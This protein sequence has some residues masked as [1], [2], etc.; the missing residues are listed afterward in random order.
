[1][2]IFFFI[3]L[4]LIP[5]A[6]FAQQYTPLVNI[7]IPGGNQGNFQDYINAIYALSIS[8]AALLA[9]IKI[10]IAGVKWMT[11]DIVPTKGEAKKDIQGALVGLLLIIGAVLIINVIN[12][13]ITEVDLSLR[14]IDVPE[15][16]AGGTE[17]GGDEV[18]PTVSN[19]CKENTEKCEFVSCATF[20]SPEAFGILG[21][22]ASPVDLALN[23]GSCGVWC[24]WRGGEITN[25]GVL[26]SGTCVYP[27]DQTPEETQQRLVDL[28]LENNP[29]C[30][31]DNC[32]VVNCPFFRTYL[33]CSD[34]CEIGQNGVTI[35]SSFFQETM[36]CVRPIQ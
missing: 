4:F 33:S 34:W 12:P 18:E 3:L 28:V 36:Q 27:T 14:T 20:D 17:I 21:Y 8:I 10:V 24:A 6:V 26:S 25:S 29:D 13:S 35:T 16:P 1:M 11:T 2:H 22:I 15:A 31:G 30:E 32:E 5:S 7:P 19:Y 23:A 9:V